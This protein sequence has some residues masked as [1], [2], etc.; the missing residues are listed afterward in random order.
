MVGG[1][2]LSSYGTQAGLQA[3][4]TPKFLVGVGLSWLDTSGSLA[5][6]FASH[7]TT[8]GVTPYVGWQFD[9]H[10]N[11]SGIAG[12]NSA[13]TALR[14]TPLAYGANYTTGQWNFQG[15]INGSYT[16]GSVRLSPV[17]SFL[18]TAIN[19]QAF[20]DSNGTRNPA[21]STNLDRGSAG[22]SL[23]LPL[24]GWEPYARAAAE[25]DFSVPTGSKPNGNAGGTIGAGTTISISD[26]ISASLDAGY[27]SLGRTGLALWSADARITLKF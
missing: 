23:S 13:H 6:G 17:V 26:A 1:Y 24:T 12:Y 8:V 21:T 22:A 18:H 10:W 20:V 16:I 15:A 2:S 5:G 4:F 7:A 3:Q 9:D 11:F 27:N 25:Y 14:D 19:N